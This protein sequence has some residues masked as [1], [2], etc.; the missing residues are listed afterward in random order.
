MTERVLRTYE[1]IWLRI[2]AREKCVVKVENEVIAGR[3]KRMVIKEKWRDEGF[4]LMQEVERF[5][6]DISYDAEKKELTFT[7]RSRLGL[8]DPV[9]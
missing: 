6:L 8:T 2:R 4:K 3:V 7:L 9:R 1:P 5:T